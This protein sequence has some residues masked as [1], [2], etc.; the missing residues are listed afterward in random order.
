MTFSEYFNLSAD[1]CYVNSS[2]DGLIPKRSLEWRRTWEEQFFAADTDLRNQQTAFLET[3]KDTIAR[4]FHA[5][6]HTVY[7]TPNFSFGYSTLIDLLPK[8]YRYLAL[9]GEYPSI[10]YP[11]ISRNL[12]YKTVKVD[13]Q[14]EENILEAIADYKPNV[15]LI[16]IVQYVSGLKIDPRFFR[17]L[18]EEHPDIW[19]IADGS[20]Y[21]GTEDFAFDRSGIDALS[22]SGYKWLCSGFGNGFLLLHQKLQAALELGLKDIPRPTTDFWSNKSVL[23]TF[24]QPGHVDTVSQGTLKESL[25]L[26]EELGLEAIGEHIAT[27]CD[28][29]YRLLAERDLLLP[30]IARRPLRSALINI[31]LDQSLYPKLMTEGIKCFPRG[32]G[33]RIGLHL[34]NELEDIHR[35]IATIDKLR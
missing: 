23:D 14:V 31:Q 16:S 33:I 4:V 6:E 10:L 18:K 29:A 13:E 3:V 26:F 5:A 24:F 22:C 15:L 19:I 21:L 20:Q 9:E 2:G 12:A 7:L 25:L 35:L 1:I 28:E 27:L 8:D 34:Y 11:I 32:T 17:R 30:E